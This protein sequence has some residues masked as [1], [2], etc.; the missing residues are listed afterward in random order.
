M[1]VVKVGDRFAYLLECCVTETAIANL[2]ND[3]VDIFHLIVAELSEAVSAMPDT[4]EISEAVSTQH[5]D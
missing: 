3:Q 4:V 2:C 5:S 1:Y